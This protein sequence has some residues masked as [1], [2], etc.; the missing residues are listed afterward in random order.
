[1]NEARRAV[2]IDPQNPFFQENLGI[3]LSD[4]ARYDEAVALFRNMFVADPNSY[5]AQDGLWDT[6]FLKGDTNE[7]LR[8]GRASFVS[9]GRQDVADAMKGSYRDAMR[10]GAEALIAARP[11]TYIGAVTI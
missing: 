5:M 10:G 3:A 7:A 9:V 8:Q 2:E 11:G 4:A 6:C 1:M